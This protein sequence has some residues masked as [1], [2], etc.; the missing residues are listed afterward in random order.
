MQTNYKKYFKSLLF[1]S[2]VVSL[3]FI[4]ILSSCS[5]DDDQGINEATLFSYG[6]MPIARGAELRFIGE[7]LSQINTI[8]LPP[9]IEIGSSE[10]TEHTDKSIKLTVPQDAVEGFITLLGDEL[11]ITTKTKIGYSE[12]IDIEGSFSPKSIKPGEILTIDGD[13]LNLVGEVLFT[14]R[15]A[16]DSSEFITKSRKQLTLKVPAEAQTGKIA[17][18]NGAEDPI[19]I[20]S[21]EELNVVTPVIAE[22]TP[23][24]V[25]PGTALTI[26]GTDLDLITAI[27]L[28]GDITVSEFASQN[29]TSL[30]MT[31]PTNALSG[32][33]ISVLPSGIEIAI[34]NITLIEPTAAIEEVKDS[35]GV[36][37]IVVIGGSDLDL[38][39]TATFTGG[40]ATP[41]T[42][43]DGKLNL[44][45]SEAAQS[46]DITL[47]TA[48]GTT[49]VVDGFVTTKPVAT[50][51]SDATPLD[52]LTI[53]ST[54]GSRV[55]TVLFGDIEAE[56][57][58][59]VDGF[60][61]VV[62]LEAETG[63]VTLVMDNG[64]TVAAG[65]ITIN[66]FTFCA[67]AEFAAESTTVG[68]LLECSVVN[69][70]NL[71]NVLLNDG[72]TPFLLVGTVLYVAVGT[73][74]GENKLTLVSGTTNVDYTIK[75]EASGLVETVLYNTPVEL[76]NWSANYELNVD[77]SGAPDDSYVRIRYT[78]TN[79]EP[80]MKAFNGHWEQ[81]Y[82]GA[83]N[84][85]NAAL[86]AASDYI[87][88]PVSLFPYSDWGYSI[89]LQG[90]GMIISSIS[91]VKD[92]SPP[93]PIW[94]GSALVSGWSTS[95]TDLTWGGYDF[96]GLQ[97][98]QTMY[99]YY[100]A[101]GSGD[102]RLGNGNWAALPSTIAIATDSG[103]DSGEGNIKITA[104]SSVI[105]FKL[106]AEDIASIQGNGGFGAYGGDYTVTKVALK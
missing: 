1:L 100:T 3:G 95:F 87:D 20:Y 12:P 30:V 13:Y 57:T 45:V 26:A 105:S 102:M 76:A 17:V 29:A 72:D 70:E 53:V 5:D 73:D 24:P 37:E 50:I 56:A 39:T 91:W 93:T 10:F 42:L 78:K 74:V 67:V 62:P 88:L 23:D 8:I 82:D 47:T 64:E 54:L 69:G 59:T 104:G 106:T 7:K 16:V 36:G 41:V 4:T 44:E 80:K 43:A 32:Q 15:V 48:N 86:I 77:F 99:V 21:E 46:G 6:P 22:V 98:G 75:V 49:V 61:V 11:S 89:I 85:D 25:K 60:K 34:G 18:S 65:S 9:N 2:V 52:E 14:D 94:E 71:T 63:S 92:F 81:V 40:E 51:P 68:E 33:A 97:V 35:Y 28:G 55:K 31:V 38:V 66:A 101:E 19:I 84:A 96:S 103:D 58:E 90:D 83:D 27:T 79:D